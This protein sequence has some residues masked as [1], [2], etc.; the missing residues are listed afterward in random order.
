MFLANRRPGLTLLEVVATVASVAILASLLA[1]GPKATR[2]NS[3]WLTCLSHLR[4]AGQAA[5]TFANSHEGYLQGASTANAIDYIDPDRTRYAYGGGEILS[6]P[7]AWGQAAGRGYQYNWDWG[8]RA[9][10]AV[11]AYS[12][13][14]HVAE[15]FE[16][17][18]CPAASFSINST[19]YPRNHSGWGAGLVGDGDPDNPIPAT[20]YMSYWGKLDYAI[21]ED[22][23]GAEVNNSAPGCWRAVPD[24]S[25]GWMGCLGE[26]TYNPN[27]PCGSQANEPLG[28]RLQGRLADVYDPATVALLADSRAELDDS[29]AVN[30]FLSGVYASAHAKEH[31]GAYLGNSTA[32]HPG[33][34]N[35]RHAAGRVNV[36]LAD[37]HTDSVRPVEYISDKMPRR[38]D[39]RVRVSP[40]DPHG[41]GQD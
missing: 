35:G 21:N 7:A 37:M 23:V 33:R 39:P 3:K 36:L 19:F 8:V 24:G 12:R 20:N 13:R 22:I 6:W 10:N 9:G 38:Y 4:E 18:T 11:G 16:A 25:G 32:V 41:L 15:D 27:S 26:F 30:L 1:A 40:Y 2:D 28:R 29:W 34:V 31:A 14:N 5:A 17:L